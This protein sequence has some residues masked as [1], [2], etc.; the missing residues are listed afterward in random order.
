VSGEALNLLVLGQRGIGG[1][2]LPPLEMTTE[3]A[4]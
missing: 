2:E 3:R 4:M 1:G